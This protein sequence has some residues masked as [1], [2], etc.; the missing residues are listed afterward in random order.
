ML[1]PIN[2]I[3][4]NN[5]GNIIHRLSMVTGEVAAD[6]GNGSYDVF[7]AGDPKAY[8]NIFTL[9]RDPDI[10][11][12]D[13]VRILY[14][15]G[16]KNNPI[17]WPP[18][19]P[20]VVPRRY[21]L[22]VSNPN[23]LQLFDKDGIL[24]KSI[25]V[26]G[27]AYGSCGVTMDSQGNIYI[28]EGGEVIKKYDE[29]LGLLA[30]QDI[31]NGNWIEGIN[32]GND[33]YLYTLELIDEGYDIKRR[34]T[35]DLT[36]IDT[37]PITTEIYYVYEG[38][39][40][41]DTAGNIYVYQNPYVEKYSSAGVKL[42]SIDVGGLNNEYAGCGI[43]GNYVY[44]VKNTDE[45]I[46]LPLDLSTYTVWDISPLDLAY[47]L[48]IAD[49]HIILSG[50]DGDN[51]GATAKYDSDR[52]LVWVKKLDPTSQYAYKAGGYNF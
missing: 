8:P 44:F 28:E 4:R 26:T 20:S 2:E 43:L 50:W 30:T 47:S 48:T 31:E 39:F 52:N 41:L 23:T 3:I 49:N 24:L 32:M 38:G 25:S 22:I 29:N 35:T 16:D 1:R 17:I 45:I 51:H 36:I 11:V 14:K 12:G 19:K 15:N 46:Y 5:V 6:N 27:W 40:C 21:T 33:G 37:I 18:E 7:I 13:T 42:A 10:A 9:A 34:S